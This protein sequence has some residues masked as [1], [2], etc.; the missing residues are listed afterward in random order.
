MSA[1]ILLDSLLLA[2]V[3]GTLALL[4]SEGLDRL[5]AVRSPHIRQQVTT[6][7]AL[8]GGGVLFFRRVEGKVIDVV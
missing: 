6:T 7:A 4:V 5:R 3:A 2:T 8:L 1:V